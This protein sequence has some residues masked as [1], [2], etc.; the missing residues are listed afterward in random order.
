MQ[1]IGDILDADVSIRRKMTDR[2]QHCIFDACKTDQSTVAFAHRRMA[3][4][5]TK[6]IMDK[7]AELLIGAVDQQFG[8]R[9][10]Q[11]RLSGRL[12]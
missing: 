9:N 10:R 7:T 8:P 1:V 3:C 12:E 5:K 6:E 4:Q 2:N 11:R